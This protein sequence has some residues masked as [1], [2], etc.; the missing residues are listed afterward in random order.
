MRDE[1]KR[2]GRGE[3]GKERERCDMLPIHPALGIH[4]PA[5]LFFFFLSTCSMRSTR[6]PSEAFPTRLAAQSHLRRTVVMDCALSSEI[7]HRQALAIKQVRRA[8]IGNRVA[9]LAA[10]PPLTGRAR[11]SS[12]PPCSSQQPAAIHRPGAR[13]NLKLAVV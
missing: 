9:G 5:T 6:F 3:G 12:K 10:F 1:E 4:L 11:R 13:C 7:R 8:C 2:N